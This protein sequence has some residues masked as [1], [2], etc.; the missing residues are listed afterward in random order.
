M[1]LVP[2]KTPCVEILRNVGVGGQ[3]GGNEGYVRYT[4]V[5][6]P[7]DAL[8]GPRGAAF[9]LGQVRLGGGRVHHAMRTVG[10][11]Q[12]ALDLMCKRA[13]SR[14]TRDGRLGDYQMVQE[15][16]ADSYIQLQQFRLQVL[17]VA[18]LIDKHKDYKKVRKDIAAVKVAMP[19]VYHDIA[20]NALHIHG[21]LGVSNEMPFMGMVTSSFVM[22]IADGPTEVH[23]ITVA[24]QLLK[25]FHPDNDLFPS[26]HL[27]KV[28]ERAK[29]KHPD[30]VEE[31][32]AEWADRARSIDAL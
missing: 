14:S 5:K 22:G 28:R 11:C 23:K 15:Q 2:R 20:A 27:P 18:W 4:N 9:E 7:F 16:I 6:V 30:L 24:K 17:H 29:S 31:L 1:F 12:K 8:L 25:N 32:R 19:K 13:V 10:Q 3:S 21:A 26:Y